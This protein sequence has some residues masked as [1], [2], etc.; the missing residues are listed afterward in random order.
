MQPCPFSSSLSS[1]IPVCPLVIFTHPQHH[2][3]TKQMHVFALSHTHT[4]TCVHTHAHTNTGLIIQ[5]LMRWRLYGEGGEI[6]CSIREQRR[7]RGRLGLMTEERWDMGRKTSSNRGI[8]STLWT[9]GRRDGKGRGEQNKAL[10]PAANFEVCNPTDVFAPLASVLSFP[11]LPPCGFT[12]LYCILL[13][14]V[15][16]FHF[17][18]F[19]Y[20]RFA[21]QLSGISW[22]SWIRNSIYE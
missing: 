3:K 6:L 12:L 5:V 17:H 14:V 22:K 2:L 13:H 4:R 15:W 9:K 18:F 11:L 20:R 21:N 7:G 19:N 10:T 16:F 8:N 1:I